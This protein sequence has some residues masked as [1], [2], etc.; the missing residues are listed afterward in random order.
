[1]NRV[2]AYTD[3]SAVVKGKAKG[4][5]GFG[6]Y[7]PDLY[8]SKAA[9]S[10]GFKTTKTGRMEL[11]ALYYAITAIRIDSAVELV[12]YSD[13]EYVVKAFTLGRLKKWIDA[14][15]K[16]TSGEVKNKDMWKAVKY[17]LDIRP[18]MTLEMIHIRSH[19]VEKQKDPTKKKQLMKDPNII[20]NM[21]ADRLA[22]H[23]RHT[24]L[25]ET[26]KLYQ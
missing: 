13:S 7:F 14:G 26:D 6:T 21:I 8:G 16:N 17:E 5:G 2:I 11:S 20:G 4:H 12:I 24:E 9:F 25:L 18:L 23:K 3:G 22:D 19:Q 15:W 10:L 1:M